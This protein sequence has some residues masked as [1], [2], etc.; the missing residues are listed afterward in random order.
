M[1][2]NIRVFAMLLPFLLADS[3]HCVNRRKFSKKISFA[4]ESSLEPTST[5][6]TSTTKLCYVF[7]K[8]SKLIQKYFHPQAI[9]AGEEKEEKR[10][11]KY[12]TKQDLNLMTTLPV[13]NSVTLIF[14]IMEAILIYEITYIVNKKKEKY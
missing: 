9:E 12:H 4:D 5:T 7:Y 8:A 3:V 6:T 2:Y 14:R 13:I 10:K 11:Y 1:K